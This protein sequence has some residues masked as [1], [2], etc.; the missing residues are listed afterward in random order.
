MRQGQVTTPGTTSPTLFDKCV[1]SLTSP[2]NHVTLKMPMVYSPYPRRPERL[3]TGTLP[4]ELTRRRF[5][6]VMI[7]SPIVKRLL[8]SPIGF[9]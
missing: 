1:G 3:T 5:Q 6:R 8:Q 7:L 2:A 9:C 4:T